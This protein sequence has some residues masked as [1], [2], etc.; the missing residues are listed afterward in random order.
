MDNTEGTPEP[1]DSVETTRG[2][3]LSK[4]QL[5][6]DY[7][8]TGGLRKLGAKYGVNY[9]VAREWLVE[10][11]IEIQKRGCNGSRHTE[12]W[13]E[14]QRKFWNDPLWKENLS[15]IA[16]A[17]WERRKEWLRPVETPDGVDYLPPA[18]AELQDALKRA[19]ISFTSNA[20]VL[21]GKYYV[22]ILLRD[23][24]LAIEIDA[25]PERVMEE[26]N[27][28]RSR[29]IRDSG[30]EITRFAADDIFAHADECVKSLNLP[31]EDNPEQVVRSPQRTY[32]LLRSAQAG[33]RK[34]DDDI[35]R[36][37]LMEK[38]QK[39]AEMTCSPDDENESK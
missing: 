30:I 26:Y 20:I 16:I 38:M 7:K 23:R 8:E 2:T 1:G 29:E 10:A 13:Y 33:R 19:S 21:R 37:A 18:E 39:Q 28:K 27:V 25:K 36:S 32:G 4:E 17:Q 22:D 9:G 3:S 5:Q 6:R 34:S 15:E 12:A 24:L 14:S 35:V 11:G 31:R